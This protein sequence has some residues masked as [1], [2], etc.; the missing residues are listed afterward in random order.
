[1]ARPSPPKLSSPPNT[2]LPTSPTQAISPTAAHESQFIPRK[3]FI[4]NH[5]ITSTF[6]LLALSGPHFIRLYNFPSVVVTALRRLLEQHNLISS[7]KE[8]TQRHFYEFTL[9]GKPWANSKSIKSEKLLI[10]VLAVVFYFGYAFLST[11]DYGREQDD[12]M[13]LSFSKPLILP[14]SSPSIPLPN[15]SAISLHQ[16]I[17]TPFAIS[18]VSQTIMRVI[19]PPLH[20]TPAVLAAVRGTWPRGVLNEQKVGDA[21][22]EFKLKGYRWFQEDTF[23][24]DSLTHILGLLSALDHEGFILLT[25]L[26]LINRSRVKDLWVFT[27]EVEETH[28]D[29]RSPTPNDSLLELKREITPQKYATGGAALQSLVPGHPP[30]PNAR[31]LPSAPTGNGHTQQHGRSISD[32]IPATS[33]PLKPKST[34]SPFMKAPLSLLRKPSPKA[35]ARQASV[36]SQTTENAVSP[37][38]SP[39]IPPSVMDMTGIGAGLRRSSDDQRTP[40]I[41]YST[42]GRPYGESPTSGFPFHTMPK[43]SQMYPP[44]S[45]LT[46]PH[47]RINV[48]GNR[49][50]SLPV[51]PSPQDRSPTTRSP[52]S[53]QPPSPYRPRRSSTPPALSQVLPPGINVQIPSP[54]IATLSTQRKMNGDVEHRDPAERDPPTDAPRPPTPHLLNPGVFRDSAFSSSTTDRQSYNEIPIAW[55]GRDNVDSRDNSRSPK[56]REEKDRHGAQKKD[57]MTRSRSGQG[58]PEMNRAPST[59]PLPPGAWSSSRGGP[60]DVVKTS[61]SN[62]TST[63]NSFP[64]PPTIKEQP[65]QEYDVMAAMLKT[66]GQPTPNK[67]EGTVQTMSPERVSPRGEG[68][69]KSE[70]ASTG[71]M[72]TQGSGSLGKSTRSTPASTPGV[73]KDVRE[74]HHHRAGVPARKETSTSGWV[75][76]NVEGKEGKAGR[77]GPHGRS[78]SEPHISSRGT[79]KLPRPLNDPTAA[80]PSSMSAAAK[81]IVMI[82]AVETAREREEKAAGS[83]FKRLW[84]RATGSPDPKKSATPTTLT[85]VSSRKKGDEMPKLQA[86]YSDERESRPRRRGGVPP[87]SVR[88]P[89]DKRLSMD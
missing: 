1:M 16:P 2:T 12:R 17:R 26:S 65:S 4:P 10:D 74:H 47:G 5:R 22:Y 31:P 61:Q 54:I 87:T 18:F 78:S 62:N 63:S 80:A 51:T 3:E 27:G 43:A 73:E 79:S 89:T 64:L 25:S 20:S 24:T 56:E 8:D 82:D 69:R 6:C 88:K 39:R 68:M 15:A 84:G 81:T 21:T 23:A 83:P 86:S 38:Q 85:P 48:P 77:P 37:E 50:S 70:A 58:R 14:A 33:S 55:T 34:T 66:N 76:V 71:L 19:G 28:P 9:E 30:S 35:L 41:F 46:T 11:I 42:S 52:S 67:L 59:G 60:D 44:P 53:Q 57:E 72:P 49:R 7:F 75:M 36:R 45:I 29:S 13:V 40:D 32:T